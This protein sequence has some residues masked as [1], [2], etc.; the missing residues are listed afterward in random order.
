MFRNSRGKAL[1]NDVL[2]RGFSYIQKVCNDD[3]LL[4]ITNNSATELPLAYLRLHIL[5]LFLLSSPPIS[6][7]SDVLYPNARS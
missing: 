2:I 3:S 7:Q 6:S 1:L 4:V 5:T